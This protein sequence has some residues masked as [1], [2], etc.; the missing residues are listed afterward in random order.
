MLYQ[1]RTR[2]CLLL[3]FGAPQVVLLAIHVDRQWP[4]LA[5]PYGVGLCCDGADFVELQEETANPNQGVKPF[6]EFFERRE[7]FKIS[8]QQVKF[9]TFIDLFNITF[10]TC[11][12]TILKL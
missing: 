1:R 5:L 10:N 11:L 12:T 3:H 6:S 7:I 8:V 9:K 4:H 2:T